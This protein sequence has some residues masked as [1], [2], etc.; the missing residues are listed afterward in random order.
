MI[1]ST[2]DGAP[3]FGGESPACDDGNCRGPHYCSTAVA[4]ADVIWGDFCP[5]VHTGEHAGLYRCSK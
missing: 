4:D 2:L 5:Y 3:E 1:L